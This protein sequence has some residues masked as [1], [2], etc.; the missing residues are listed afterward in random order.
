[1]TLIS[2][3]LELCIQNT[4]TEFI[5]QR[6]YDTDIVKALNIGFCT[7]DVYS[8]L[9]K[10][11]GIDVLK[12][13]GF[14]S[15]SGHHQYLGRA[16]FKYD[17]EYFSARKVDTFGFPG[18]KNLF[19][20]GLTK[21]PYLLKGTENIIYICEG[22]TDAVA[23]KH[24]FPNAWIISLGGTTMISR[25]K[26]YV[27]NLYL[28]KPKIIIAFDKDDAGTDCL[29]KAIKIMK[30]NPDL[31]YLFWDGDY[32]DV[33]ECF[34]N[35]ISLKEKKIELKAEETK[36][37]T[38]YSYPNPVL[39]VIKGLADLK[40]MAEMLWAKNPF[41]YDTSKIFWFWNKQEFFYEQV[42]DTTL[43]NVVDSVFQ[44][45]SLQSRQ[46]ASILE[47]LRQVGRKHIPKAIDKWWVQYKSN[48]VN[49]KTSEIFKV[50]PEFFF[51]TSIPWDIGTIEDTPQMDKYIESWVVKKGLQD[52]SYIQTIYE[53]IAYFCLNNQF[54]QVIIALTGSGSNGKGTCRD[55][56][57]KFIGDK[58]YS[59]S[60]MKLLTTKQFETSNIYK[61]AVCVMPEVDSYDMKNT[62][63]L[64]QLC[65]E[66]P[67][68]YE[69][70]GKTPFSDYS[71]TKIVVLTNSLPI[72][73]DKSLGFYR[74]WL[75]I[76]FPH[77]FEV[78]FDVLANIPDCEYNNLAKK[79]IRILKE[80]IERKTFTNGGNFL[81]RQKRY[82]ER[83]NPVEKFVNENCIIQEG[84]CP[85]PTLD[86]CKKVNEYLKMKGL[87]CMKNRDITHVLKDMEIRVGN[88]T[89]RENGEPITLTGV[90][91]QWNNDISIEEQTVL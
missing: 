43:L 32:K 33:A 87:R 45:S 25:L 23:L 88:K 24:L 29:E 77:I 48:V 75:I 41:F 44:I 8:V 27:N 89:V 11:F 5:E 64:K 49:A 35:K 61:K 50:I 17:D 2:R 22:E 1:M 15:K 36:A 26:H 85:I 69:F 83:S 59:S 31:Y 4:P 30:T 19:P 34:K 16:I 39:S 13:T 38:Y 63:R 68:R 54:L 73:T 57:K 66:D 52:K 82:E 42:D 21:R 71:T 74:R 51:T 90:W 60:E 72:T 84:L 10:E 37:K 28:K 3:F 46:K 67:I 18:L 70:K 12:E 53:I 55:I 81:E 14:V 78:G 91:I 20:R 9:I 62:A 6:G 65:G 79:S 7:Q 56:I 76:D 80:L 58:N 86:F 40:G 47:A